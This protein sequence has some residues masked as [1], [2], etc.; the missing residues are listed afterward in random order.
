MEKIFMADLLRGKK[1][2]EEWIGGIVRWG[3]GAQIDMASEALYV[4]YILPE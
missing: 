2:S 4:R 3:G 1:V